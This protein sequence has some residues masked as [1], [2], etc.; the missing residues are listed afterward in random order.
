MKSEITAF[1]REGM[2]HNTFPMDKDEGIA[3]CRKRREE[4]GRMG[5]S[6]QLVFF[7]GGLFTIKGVD[8]DGNLFDV[9]TNATV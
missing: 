6:T 8:K 1:E 5:I 7:G 2:S 3:A 4:L 9:P